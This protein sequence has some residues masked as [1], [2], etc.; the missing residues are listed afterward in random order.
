[1]PSTDKVVVTPNTSALE[2][3]KKSSVEEAIEN[4]IAQFFAKQHKRVPSFVNSHF[5]YPGC[6]HTNKHAFGFDLIKAP[7]NLIWAPVY[8]LIIILLLMLT[9]L[10]HKRARTWAPK[11]PSGMTTR[12]QQR[13][14][15]HIKTS[16]LNPAELKQEIIDQ[17]SQLP[18]P[19]AQSDTELLEHLD[20]IVSEVM[21][22]LMLT[23]T[24]SADIANTLFST[25]FGALIFKKFTPGGFGIGLLIAAYWVKEKAKQNFFLGATIG[26]WYYAIFPPK[27]G[28]LENTVGIAIA[29]LILATIASF[30]GLVTDPV[31]AWLRLHHRRL[32]KM[33][34]QL[35]GDLANRRSS[36][37][38]TLDPYV[39]RILELFDTV[40]SQISL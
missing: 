40:K 14:N 2:K 35:E 26:G 12:V 28:W 22:Q 10:G 11:V 1:M 20:T 24:A 21:S 30:S 9:L 17:L 15:Q 13:V 33:L 16:L 39:A 37:F 3:H 7:L 31:Q 34:N 27:V 18:Q 32:H 25:A 38:K 5:R 6:W 4:G 19:N 23:R 29:M 8:V 36:Q